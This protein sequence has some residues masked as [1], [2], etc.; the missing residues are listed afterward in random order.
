MSAQKYPATAIYPIN[1]GLSGQYDGSGWG[2]AAI[3][4]GEVVTI[5]YIRNI[6][7]QKVVDQIE[8]DSGHATFFI[9]QW[10]ST[11]E[12]SPT[13][14]ELQARG[15]VSVGMFSSWEFVEI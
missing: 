15:Q 3:S 14:R 9:N 5:R 8:S 7:S 11:K 10:L 1:A 4:G 12:A 13:L 2:L 6:A